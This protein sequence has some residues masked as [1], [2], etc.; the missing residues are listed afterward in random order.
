MDSNARTITNMFEHY[1]KVSP[2]EEMRKAA[3]E[4]SAKL[5]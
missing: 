5:E 1:E 4:G 2:D 3:H